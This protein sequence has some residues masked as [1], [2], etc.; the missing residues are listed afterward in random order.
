[1]SGVSLVSVQA[2]MRARCWPK[3]KLASSLLVMLFTFL[4]SLVVCL[5]VGP[6]FGTTPSGS[7]SHPTYNAHICIDM[8]MLQRV[9]RS[10]VIPRVASQTL[11]SSVHVRATATG[12]R[13]SKVK[14]VRR[15]TRI[16]GWLMLI[17][18]VIVYFYT[19]FGALQ[20]AV[21]P[22]ELAMVKR[23]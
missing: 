1:M 7:G 18:T 5:C 23:P 22:R 2:I 16:L 19:T 10:I 20:A 9:S 11:K 4:F 21:K 17:T 8:A 6:L 15:S 12:P 13:R 3:S 14:V